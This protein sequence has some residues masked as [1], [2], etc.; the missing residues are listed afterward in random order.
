M[1][2]PIRPK[3]SASDVQ[4]A[5]ELVLL[6]AAYATECVGPKGTVIRVPEDDAQLIRA[7]FIGK[8]A[9]AATK[10][11]NGEPLSREQP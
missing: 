1:P 11:A 4:S 8:L 6:I 2:E 5:G 7:T 3:V 10:I 9:E